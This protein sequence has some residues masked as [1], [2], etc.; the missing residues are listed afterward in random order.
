MQMG[1]QRQRVLAIS[2]VF[3]F[4]VFFYISLIHWWLVAPL[5]DMAD[6]DVVLQASY[7][8]YMTLEAQRGPVQSRLEAL[9]QLSVPSVGL[10]NP[11][12]PEV[13]IAQLM[14]LVLERLSSTPSSGVA[15]TVLNRTPLAATADN[16]LIKV[17]VNVDL[18]CGIESLAG[19]L[20]KLEGEMPYL[21][22]ETLSV[23]RRGA[24]PGTSLQDNRLTVKM[25]ISG[26]QAMT[27]VSIK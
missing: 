20:H 25:Q 21:T 14:Q 19:T 17:R 27:Q 6:E 23:Q 9:Q 8:R 4:G 2:L 7:Q 10:L 12:G 13:A 26:F 22:V 24:I 11:G 1:Q 5:M 3:I 16:S 18:E 15:C